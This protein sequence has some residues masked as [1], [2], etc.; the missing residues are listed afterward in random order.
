MTWRKL[1]QNVII[2]FSFYTGNWQYTSPFSHQLFIFLAN[3][4][5]WPM[6]CLQLN[7]YGI[8]ALSY[9]WLLQT[10]H[11]STNQRYRYVWNV[12]ALRKSEILISISGFFT[13][14]FDIYLFCFVPGLQWWP[15]DFNEKWVQQGSNKTTRHRTYHRHPEVVVT[16]SVE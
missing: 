5:Q 8:R 9:M 7:Q 11:N 3:T 13:L 1:Y 10:W 4:K 6:L 12:L 2:T 14:I 16:K 15:M